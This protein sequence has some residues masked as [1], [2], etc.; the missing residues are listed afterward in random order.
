MDSFKEI[1]KKNKK[2]ALS[3]AIASTF[4]VTAPNILLG[5]D[6]VNQKDEEE[7]G[8]AT[9]T[10]NSHVWHSFRSG[11]SSSSKKSSV[12]KSSTSKSSGYSGVKGGSSS[13]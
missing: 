5:C 12:T 3:I 9:S 11:G 2:R 7:N 6:N 1:F 13:S 8:T 10:H 4:M